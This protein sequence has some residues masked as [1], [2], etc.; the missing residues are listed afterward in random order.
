M[1]NITKLNEND[2][3]PKKQRVL[4]YNST[5]CYLKKR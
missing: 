5:A 2:I 3:K 1:E 4:H